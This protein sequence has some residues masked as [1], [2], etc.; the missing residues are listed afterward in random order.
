[1]S[2]S[3][4][5]INSQVACALIEMHGMVAENVNARITSKTFRVEIPFR[6][7]DFDAL[8][9]KYQIGCNAVISELNREG[10]R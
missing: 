1:M 4:T 9:E 5:L 6:K 7:K 8:I 3:E 2:R 10:G